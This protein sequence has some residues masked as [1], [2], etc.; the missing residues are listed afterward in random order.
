MRYIIEKSNNKLY[1]LTII[2]KQKEYIKRNIVY[3]NNED[4]HNKDALK[5]TLYVLTNLNKYECLYLA[6]D[7]NKNI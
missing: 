4:L 5:F 2:R 7:I 1:K 3:V 6:E